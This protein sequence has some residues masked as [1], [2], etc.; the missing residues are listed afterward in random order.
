MSASIGDG[1]R[2]VKIGASGGDRGRTCLRQQR[3]R[4]C[5]EYSIAA[6][7]DLEDGDSR[8]AAVWMLARETHARLACELRLAI[9]IYMPGWCDGASL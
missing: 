5:C 2:F 6:A 9:T 1:P 3:P 7:R 8:Y 4:R